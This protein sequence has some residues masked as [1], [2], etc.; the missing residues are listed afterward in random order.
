MSLLSPFEQSRNGTFVNSKRVEREQKLRIGDLIGL[1][2]NPHPV[3]NFD[4][5]QVVFSLC[6][7]PQK[8]ILDDINME[9]FSFGAAEPDFSG[10]N[11]EDIL[12]SL[13]DDSNLSKD[14]IDMD[15]TERLPC[16]IYQEEGKLEQNQNN[17]TTDLKCDATVSSEPIKVVASLAEVVP[18]QSQI[19]SIEPQMSKRKSLALW[20]EIDLDTEK[21]HPELKRLS[22]ELVKLTE[23]DKYLDSSKKSA[24]GK[25][26]LKE[27]STKASKK[28]A[29]VDKSLKDTS[30]QIKRAPK[31]SKSTTDELD[32]SP[33]RL[34]KSPSASLSSKVKTESPSSPATPKTIRKLD[35]IKGSP[36][37]RKT[38]TEKAALVGATA[39]ASNE[40]QSFE[41]SVPRMKS[42]RSDPSPAKQYHIISKKPAKQLKSILVKS[43]KNK[44]N[45][46]KKNVKVTFCTS[47]YI[48]EYIQEDDFD[49]EPWPAAA[50][51]G[52][53]RNSVH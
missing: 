19:I 14:A 49:S 7:A 26:K 20:E 43:E 8:V 37:P 24:P 33:K 13:E 18:C 3:R 16:S 25:R 47:V 10:I 53:A 42:T 32:K 45:V 46:R 50:R 21:Y 29:K 31:V 52:V 36:H 40:K 51:A 35:K 22:V 1:G 38:S 12:K 34:K 27:N 23:I 44:K 2:T 28:V 6:S 4:E 30:K 11:I 15:I 48:K 39:T 5:H 9:L 41:T 17:M